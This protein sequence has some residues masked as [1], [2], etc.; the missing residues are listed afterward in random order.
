MKYAVQNITELQI[1]LGADIA[2]ETEHG[3]KKA[4]SSKP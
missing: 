4:T 2:R 1:K 3:A